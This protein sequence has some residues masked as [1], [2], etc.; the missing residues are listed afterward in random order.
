M[1]R[2][3]SPSGDSR[4]R[5]VSCT[6]CQRDTWALNAVCDRCEEMRRDAELDR[7]EALADAEDAQWEKH[8]DAQRARP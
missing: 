5:P 3:V 7:D 8:A 6:R 4:E 2:T 1:S